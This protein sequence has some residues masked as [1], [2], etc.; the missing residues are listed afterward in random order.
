M[1]EKIKFLSDAQLK[2]EMDRCL[3]CEEKPCKTACPADCSPAD[4]IMAARLMEKSDLKRSAALIMGN[5]TFG[6]VCGAGLGR[7]RALSRHNDVNRV[8]SLAGVL[9]F[10]SHVGFSVPC[11]LRIR[12]QPDFSTC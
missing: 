6:G 8:R 1:S 9:G 12:L 4:F 11:W 2:T 7:G 3:Y 10:V 5:N